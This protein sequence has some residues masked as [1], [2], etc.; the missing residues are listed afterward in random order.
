MK[1]YL[2]RQSKVDFHKHLL[3]KRRIVNKK[4][5]SLGIVSAL[6]STNQNRRIEYNKGRCSALNWH[7]QT[8]FTPIHTR[9]KGKDRRR[10]NLG[11][12]EGD[13]EG[14]GLGWKYIGRDLFSFRLG[15]QLFSARV[16]ELRKQ[17][18]LAASAAPSNA[19]RE[20]L[21]RLFHCWH[22]PGDAI[23]ISG[24]SRDSQVLLEIPC[25]RSLLLS[26]PYIR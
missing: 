12:E 4:K 23:T 19:Q 11:E 24:S 5:S 17:R 14:R 25:L 13:E 1:R 26:L 16:C 7:R 15:C 2:I 10:S 22:H 9:E 20:W 6:Q 21:I 3:C 18:G 8:S